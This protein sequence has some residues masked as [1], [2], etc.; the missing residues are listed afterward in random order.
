ME[1]WRW[2]LGKLRD[3]NLVL[4]TMKLQKLSYSEEIPCIFYNRN[5]H[6]SYVL[7]KLVHN[8]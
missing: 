3:K 8:F 6:L 7:F 2:F 4:E 1:F 5:A